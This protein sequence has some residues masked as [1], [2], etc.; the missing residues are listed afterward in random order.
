MTVLRQLQNDENTQYP[1]N[2]TPASIGNFKVSDERQQSHKLDRAHHQKQNQSENNNG[3][4]A[5]EQR[6][7]AGLELL[8]EAFQINNESHHSE[9]VKYQKQVENLELKLQHKDQ[10]ISKLHSLVESLQSK[11]GQM[12]KNFQKSESSRLQLLSKYEHLKLN[13]QRLNGFRKQIAQMVEHTGGVDFTKLDENSFIG[14][15]EFP[16][17]HLSSPIQ[18]DFADQQD[19]NDDHDASNQENVQ[20][21]VPR[22]SKYASD[23]PVNQMRDSNRLRETKSD[24]EVLKLTPFDVNTSFDAPYTAAQSSPVQRMKATAAVAADRVDHTDRIINSSLIVDVD[25]PALYKRIRQAMSSDEFQKFARYISDFNSGLLGADDAMLM[26][27]GKRILNRSSVQY[28][29]GLL[30]SEPQL[31]REMER[32]ILK[33]IS[34]A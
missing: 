3:G 10:E 20:N 1:Q 9:I 11:N 28:Q 26:I 31:A 30:S 8:Q 25:V 2:L 17:L 19:Y 4:D 24:A 29:G 33:A 22:L 34:E 18:S 23:R 15:Q 5:A 7:R 12:K 32:L 16:D 13:Y 6:F 21:F 14:G 27:V